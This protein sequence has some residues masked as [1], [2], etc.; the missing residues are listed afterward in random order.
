MKADGGD[1]EGNEAT[2]NGQRTLISKSSSSSLKTV[3][4]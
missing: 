4:W 3:Q 1:K 2:I